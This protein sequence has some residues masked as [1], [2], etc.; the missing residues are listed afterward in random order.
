VWLSDITYIKTDEGT[1]YLNLIT[2][3]YSRKIVGYSIADNMTT[4]VMETAYATA[5]KQRKYDHPLIRSL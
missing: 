4:E 2:D 3:G 1:C 5:L